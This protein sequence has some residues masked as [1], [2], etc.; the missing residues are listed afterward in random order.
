MDSWLEKTKTRIKGS[1]YAKYF[2]IVNNHIKPSLGEH[3]I[4]EIASTVINAFIMDKL[5]NGKL[6]AIG[7]LSEKTVRDIITVIKSVLRFA[8]DEG[9]LS[10]AAININLPRERAKEMKVLT[11][12]EQSALEKYLCVDI[13]ESK[14]GV[15]VC[16]YTGLRIGEICSL[17]WLDI[18]LDEKTLTVSRTIQRMQTFDDDCLSR[19]K[20]L[21]T[22]PKSA[23]SLRTVPLPDCLIDKLRQLCSIC[24]NAY[25]LTG[26]TERVHRA[27]D[28]P[29]PFEILLC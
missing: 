14:L 17:K 26:E 15:L 21:I 3:S 8:K 10:D 16:M 11:K 28:T 9:L 20:V 2:N 4:S 1:F 18:S 27:E 5:K 24:P 13:D 7:G 12:D 23:C 6:G 29:E 22:D 19:T 25:L